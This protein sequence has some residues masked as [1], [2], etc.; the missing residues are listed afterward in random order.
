MPIT[1]TLGVQRFVGHVAYVLYSYELRTVV[2]AIHTPDGFKIE[3]IE[4]GGAI[5]S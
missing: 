3:L 2:A 4:S 1:S 5:S